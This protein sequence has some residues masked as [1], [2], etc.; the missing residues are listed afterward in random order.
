M[1]E[2][3]IFDILAVEIPVTIGKDK[4]I[5][6]EASGEAACQYRNKITACARQTGEDMIVDG[7]IADADPLLISHCLFKVNVVKEEEVVSRAHVNIN[8]V[9]AWPERVLKVLVAKIKEISPLDSD[10]DEDITA[11]EKEREALTKKIEALEAAKNSQSNT[12]D[13]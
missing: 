3:L 13:G 1:S 8:V 12:T 10:G 9:R 2:E 4:Y 7:P 6:R 5:L 11:L